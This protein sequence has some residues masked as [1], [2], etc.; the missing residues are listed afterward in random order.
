MGNPHNV[1]EATGW[2]QGS[3]LGGRNPG[4]R[5]HG[6][7]MRQIVGEKMAKGPGSLGLPSM[8]GEV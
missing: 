7:E 6:L 3:G 5:G 8:E 4:F 2:E 1:I